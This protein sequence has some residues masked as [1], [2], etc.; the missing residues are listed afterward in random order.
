L[1]VFNE[2]QMTVIN[3]A[4]P[5]YSVAGLNDAT[6]AMQAAINAGNAGDTIW[7][8]AGLGARIN[9]TAN[10]MHL[11]YGSAIG[12]LMKSGLTLQIDGTLQAL[13]VKPDHYAMVVVDGATDVTITGKG[14]IIGDRDTH[15][16]AD[17]AGQWGFGIALGNASNVKIVNG[18]T[19]SKC[20][21]DGITAIGTGGLVIDHIVC[22][23]NFR[24]NCSLINVNGFV[25][26]NN[27]F[28]NAGQSNLDLEPSVAGQSI[29]N[30]KIQYNNFVN[31]GT[32][33]PIGTKKVHLGIG[34]SP[35]IGTFKGIRVADCQFD[36]K[37]QPIW[38]HDTAGTTGIP[39]WAY[40]NNVIFYQTLK[41]PAYRFTGYP[42][43]WSD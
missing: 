32:L 34:S 13:T 16:A 20:W 6:A 11:Y 29:L 41:S 14:R 42:T 37:Q 38:V 25:I 31:C 5:P 28:S 1:I 9:P 4:L 26:T 24:Q 12:L 2:E 8:P 18:L 33:Y 7:L 19:I 36:L 17:Q 22:D 43:S 23:S 40:L 3:V 15:V 35:G 39:W 30:G 27:T 21:G 10:A